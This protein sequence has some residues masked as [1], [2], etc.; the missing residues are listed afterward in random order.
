MTSFTCIGPKGSAPSTAIAS[1]S[2]PVWS[3]PVPSTRPSSSTSLQVPLSLEPP[4]DV[5]RAVRPNREGV[6]LEAHLRRGGDIQELRGAEVVVAPAVVGGQ[7]RDADGPRG[8]SA[9]GRDLDDA[10]VV[11]EPAADGREQV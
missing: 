9:L 10:V 5:D 8:A 11:G 6:G 4:G 7:A 3:T 1:R 2:V